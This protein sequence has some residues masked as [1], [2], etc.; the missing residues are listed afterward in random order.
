[1]QNVQTDMVGVASALLAK[2]SSS[3]TGLFLLLNLFH[4]YYHMALEQP[5]TCL[6]SKG[7]AG[8]S[9][10][11][12]VLCLVLVSDWTEYTIFFSNIILK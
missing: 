11:A 12:F 10:E 8:L 9:S 6:R 3:C 7:V 5:Q 4:I 2:V 1:M